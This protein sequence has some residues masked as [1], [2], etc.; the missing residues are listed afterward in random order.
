MNEQLVDKIIETTD[1]V[2]LLGEELYKRNKM[3]CPHCLSKIMPTAITDCAEMPLELVDII[4]CKDC[5]GL[6]IILS[7]PKMYLQKP[8]FLKWTPTLKEVKE[9]DQ[10]QKQIEGSEVPAGTD[11]EA[12][13]G[14]ESEG[15]RSNNGEAGSSLSRQESETTA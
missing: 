2:A 12:A 11:K 14:D 7:F 10:E 15:T 4:Q 8:V 5:K 6:S 3:A 1:K 13:T 9:D